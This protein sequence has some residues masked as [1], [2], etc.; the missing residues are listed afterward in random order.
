MLQKNQ[1]KVQLYTLETINKAQ[2]KKFV[3]ITS[4]PKD[5]GG[6]VDIGTGNALKLGAHYVM[7]TDNAIFIWVV[8]YNPDEIKSLLRLF[9]GKISKI[10]LPQGTANIRGLQCPVSQTSKY[11]YALFKVG[12]KNQLHRVG[13][14]EGFSTFSLGNV[15]ALIDRPGVKSEVAFAAEDK[16][17]HWI[18]EL[19]PDGTEKRE[20]PIPAK[21]KV[22]YFVYLDF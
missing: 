2:G 16:G 22:A 7:K 12:G 10:R 9:N 17:S 8:S 4:I 3:P 15:Y 13:D 18:I 14:T 19:K 20:R 1:E 11:L 5:K 21:G 6:E